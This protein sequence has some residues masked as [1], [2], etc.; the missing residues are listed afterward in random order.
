MESKESFENT[1]TRPGDD[2][3]KEVAAE[4]NPRDGCEHRPD[5]NKKESIIQGLIIRQSS[6]GEVGEGGD[7]ADAGG[8]A[9]GEGEVVDGYGDLHGGGVV[10]WR[11]GAGAAED[12]FDEANESEVEKE[13]EEERGEEGAEQSGA[14]EEGKGDREEE[15]EVGG[16][17]EE[18]EEGV[19]E[20][21]SGYGVE[22]M[23][24][25]G[26]YAY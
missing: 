8:M 15:A 23:G 14:E 19:G 22:V 3:G 17:L 6:G 7:E 12:K 16:E 5:P 18:E 11:A 25:G 4:K 24:D 13:T 26:V 2:I 21:R 10:V 1:Q 9:A 20:E